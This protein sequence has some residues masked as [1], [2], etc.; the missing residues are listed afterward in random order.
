MELNDIQIRSP[1]S[2]KNLMAHAKV[3]DN[4]LVISLDFDNPR[5]ALAQFLQLAGVKFASKNFKNWLD[6]LERGV[7]INPQD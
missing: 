5:F 1:E 2:L 4:D 3:V 7:Q 6:S